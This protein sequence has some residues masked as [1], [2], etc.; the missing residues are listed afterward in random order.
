MVLESWC[1]ASLL[2]D[3]NCLLTSIY[4]VIL[5]LLVF[6][7][8]YNCKMSICYWIAVRFMC[9][10]VKI[11]RFEVMMPLWLFYLLNF[12]DMVNSCNNKMILIKSAKLITFFR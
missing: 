11:A 1:V 7:A 5:L 9:F 10:L 8:A 12:N 2:T 3:C 6:G 4:A